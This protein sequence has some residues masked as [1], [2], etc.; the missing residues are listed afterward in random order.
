MRRE[1]VFFPWERNGKQLRTE[2]VPSKTRYLGPLGN[3][4]GRDGSARSKDGVCRRRGVEVSMRF[5][6]DTEQVLVAVDCPLGGLSHTKVLVNRCGWKERSA[7]DDV[8]LL[9]SLLT[10]DPMND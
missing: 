2:T 5:G 1:T 7:V 10:T 8:L 6:L 3:E 4:E 9:S